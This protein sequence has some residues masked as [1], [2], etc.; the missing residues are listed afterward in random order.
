MRMALPMGRGWAGLPMTDPTWHRFQQR[1]DTGRPGLNSQGPWASRVTDAPSRGPLLSG[2]ISEDR[3]P[4]AG[5]GRSFGRWRLLVINDAGRGSRL[6]L[7]G[8]PLSGPDFLWMA[9]PSS[10][11]E[12]PWP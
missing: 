6:H 2:Q 8:H 9:L 11:L 1:P 4:G 5:L 10:G 7:Q 3:G 12:T